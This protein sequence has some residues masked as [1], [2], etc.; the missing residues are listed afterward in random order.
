[1]GDRHALLTA[2]GLGWLLTLW[3][4]RIRPDA[5]ALKERVNAIAF[6]SADEFRLL[7][8]SWERM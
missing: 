2:A 6:A 3:I 4:D 8:A 5:T 1:M 7:R